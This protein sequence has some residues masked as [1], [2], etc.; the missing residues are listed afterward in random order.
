MSD[1]VTKKSTEL[2]AE[3]FK[4][5]VSKHKVIGVEL[6]ETLI[7]GANVKTCGGPK[8]DLVREEVRIFKYLILM[9]CFVVFEYVGFS[10]AEL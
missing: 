8:S 2:D 6:L 1:Y 10:C 7:Q 3:Y 5:L 9:C 4:E